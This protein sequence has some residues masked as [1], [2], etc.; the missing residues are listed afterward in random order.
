MLID[1]SLGEA[2]DRYSILEIKKNEIND[3]NK[4]EHIHKELKL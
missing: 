4:L 1:I 3:N 2:L